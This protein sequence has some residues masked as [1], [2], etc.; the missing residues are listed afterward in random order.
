M[1]ANAALEPKG[2]VPM[3]NVCRSCGAT[4]AA[5]GAAAARERAEEEVAAE[6]EKLMGPAPGSA[7]DAA[8]ATTAPAAVDE[9]DRLVALMR[10]SKSAQREREQEEVAAELE[11]LMGP[12]QTPASA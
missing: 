4:I 3:S 8:P 9:V 2:N 10:P 1:A 12:P 6:I 11:K 7:R 5:K